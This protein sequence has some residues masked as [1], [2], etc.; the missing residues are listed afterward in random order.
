MKEEERRTKEN[1][2]A[3]GHSPIILSLN[4]KEHG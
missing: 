3:K 4:D 1:N 2:K